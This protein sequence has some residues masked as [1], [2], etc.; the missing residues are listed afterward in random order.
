MA[1]TDRPLHVSL[2]AIPEAAISTLT[3]IYDVMSVFKVLS[4]SSM[5]TE[6]SITVM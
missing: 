2:V 6:P 5:S 1:A 4:G 3:G